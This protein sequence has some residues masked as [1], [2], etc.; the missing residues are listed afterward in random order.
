M[1]KVSNMSNNPSITDKRPR[2]LNFGSKTEKLSSN[3]QTSYE[4]I[5]QQGPQP[6]ISS[7]GLWFLHK[8]SSFYS[9]TQPASKGSFYRTRIRK[10]FPMSKPKKDGLQMGFTTPHRSNR[11]KKNNQQ[12]KTTSW[13]VRPHGT[14]PLY[15]LE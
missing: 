12:K 11:K 3:G 6:N 1:E 5:A 8:E 4:A 13:S 15:F 14:S 7:T 2:E 10:T 9:K